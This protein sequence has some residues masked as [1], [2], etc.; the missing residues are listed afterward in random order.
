[1]VID[2]AG[3]VA[4]IDDAETPGLSGAHDSLAYRVNE[5]EHHFHV[6]ERWFGLANT[7]SGEDHR[8]DP[9]GTTVT[10][11]TMDAGN[12]TWGD[13][14][15]FVGATDTPTDGTARY[16]DM[17]K[18]VVTYV[19]RASTAH[20]IQIAWGTSG[21]A[22]YAAGDYTEFVYWAGANVSREAPIELRMPRIATG[23]KMWMRV[24]AVG[25]DTGQVSAFCGGHEY[26]G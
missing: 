3:R 22:A 7:P 8:G 26:P 5:V 10:P 13:W 25:K 11:F 9:I 6:K 20:F 14:L 21:A 16:M 19:E 17:H 12:V 15:Q 24:L 2:L 1:M 4:K 18:M 23:T